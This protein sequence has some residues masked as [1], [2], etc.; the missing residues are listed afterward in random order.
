MVLTAL[1]RAVQG[2]R[3]ARATFLI[4]KGANVHIKDR[5]AKAPLDHLKGVRGTEAGAL[6]RLLKSHA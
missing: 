3:Y 4:E 1:S 5:A 6:R 2:S